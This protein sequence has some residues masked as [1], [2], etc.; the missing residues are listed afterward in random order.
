MTRAPNWERKTSFQP[1]TTRVFPSDK[2]PDSLSSIYV[3]REPSPVETDY[4]TNRV[5]MD[6]RYFDMT[7]CG[8][9][10]YFILAT[11]CVENDE[12]CHTYFL[13]I[14]KYFVLDCYEFQNLFICYIHLIKYS[15]YFWD[16]VKV[17]WLLDKSITQ[18]I[19]YIETMLIKFWILPMH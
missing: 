4:T 2:V 16:Q 15:F 14:G 9:Y 17:S 5:E 12:S 1:V 10:P 3:P 6:G 7:V 8:G 11:H 13:S 18:N 19:V